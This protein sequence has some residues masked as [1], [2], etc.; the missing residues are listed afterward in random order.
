MFHR[1][2][3][4]RSMSVEAAVLARRVRIAGA[5]GVRGIAPLA[6]QLPP[7][8]VREGYGR[9]IEGPRALVAVLAAG[10]VVPGARARRV[11]TRLFDFVCG[12]VGERRETLAV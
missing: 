2:I 3:V 4:T 6:L 7:G 1:A 8:A 5:A 11:G 10:R 12:H 9:H